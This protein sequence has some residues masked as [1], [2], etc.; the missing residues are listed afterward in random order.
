MGIRAVYWRPLRGDDV[1]VVEQVCTARATEVMAARA[2]QI[3]P[4]GDG[5]L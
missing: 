5:A 3:Q 4:L 2:V 1:A